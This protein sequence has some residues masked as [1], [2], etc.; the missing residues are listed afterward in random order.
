MILMAISKE[1]NKKL[2]TVEADS[3]DVA[4]LNV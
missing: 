3:K 2:W 4:Y 1:S